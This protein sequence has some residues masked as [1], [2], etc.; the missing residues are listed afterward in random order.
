MSRF[1]DPITSRWWTRSAA[2]KWPAFR[3]V[4]CPSATA[5]WLFRKMRGEQLPETI[6][7]RPD[8]WARAELRLQHFDN[9][10]VDRSR[11]FLEPMRYTRWNHDHVALAQLMSFAALN[12]VAE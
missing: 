9:V 8:P 3:W 12:I 4:R 2:K 1:P 11:Y 5:W 7:L 10:I 6:Q